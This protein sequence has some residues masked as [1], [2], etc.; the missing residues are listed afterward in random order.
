[1]TASELSGYS[2]LPEPEL[3]FANKKLHRH[4]L[5]GILKHGPYSVQLGTP[6]QLRLALLAPKAELHRLQ[7][8]LQELSRKAVPR[9]AKNY[10]P[11]YPG[12]EKAFRI[13][14]ANPDP[15]VVIELPASLERIS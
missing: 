8:L 6:S 13:R 3:L 5:V 14:V 1:M 10:Y 2:T 11:E 7:S 15:R 12:F 9:E 4:P